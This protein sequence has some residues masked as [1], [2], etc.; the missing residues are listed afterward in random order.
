MPNLFGLK[1]QFNNANNRIVQQIQF[2]AN[3]FNTS[4]LTR[5]SQCPLRRSDVNIVAQNYFGFHG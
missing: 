3:K 2:R 1:I 4:F 5:K